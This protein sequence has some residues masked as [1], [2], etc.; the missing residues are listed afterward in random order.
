MPA[1]VGSPVLYRLHT[2]S[3][4]I[5]QIR[6]E[7]VEELEMLRDRPKRVEKPYIYHLDVGAMYPNIILTNRLQP[8]AIVDDTTCAACDY[9]QAKNDCK[10]R[11]DWVWRGDYSPASKNEYE[12]TKDQ[13]SREVIEG[14][15]FASFPEQE[16]AKHV[17]DRLKTYSRKAYKK[18][19]VTEEETRKDVVCMREN[20]FYVDTV[21]QFRDR[22]Y[23]YKKM[24]NS[25][26]KKRDSAPDAAAKKEA[27]D[28]VVVYDSL[29]VAH[30]CIL[31]SFYGYVMR[32]GAR[33]RS[34]EMAGIVTKTGSDIITEARILVEQIGRPLELDTDGIWCILP[35][36]FPDVYT[37]KTS[38]GSKLKLEYP[39]V[40]LNADVHDKFTNHQYQTL[41][42]PKRGIYETRSECSIFFEVDGPYRC[43]VIPA[44][45]EEG[46]LLKKRYAV[47][48][49]D[50]SLAELKGFELKRRGE[51]ELIK[52]FQSQVFERFLDGNSLKECY[53]SVADVANHW[54]DVI[55]TRGDSLEDDELID[56]ISE[57]RNMSR[58]LE[59]YGDQKGTSQTTARRLAEFLGADLIK[60]KGLNCKFII[61][62]QPY[63]APV[64]ERAIP[65]NIWK[66]EPGV[67]KHFLRKWMKSPGLDGDSLDIRNVLDWDYYLGRLGKTIQK[68][69]TIP[70]ALQ[71]VPNPVPRVEHPSWL[72]SK[73]N[74]LNDKFQQQSIR[75][76]FGVKGPSETTPAALVDIEDF[77]SGKQVSKRPIVHS[78]KRSSKNARE[79][80]EQKST[81]AFDNAERI[82]LS[83]E[84]FGDW[85]Q[86]KKALWQNSRRARKTLDAARDQGGVDKRQRKA[87]SMEGFVRKA[88]LSLTEREWQVIEVRGMT[89]YDALAP[90]SQSSGSGDFTVWVMTGTDSLQKISVTVPRTV[91]ISTRKEI[92]NVSDGTGMLELRKVDKHLPHSKSAAFV[93]E[94][95]MPEHIYKSK[96]WINYLKPVDSTEE[97]DDIFDG[98]Y[99]TDTPLM[100]RVLSE[101]GCLSRL[102]SAGTLA[103]ARKSYSLSELSR[104]ERPSEGEYLHSKLSYKRLFLY[105]KVHPRS[106]T[107]I[108]AL[109]VLD[110]GSGSFLKKSEDDEDNQSTHEDVTR[111][112]EATPA[113]FDI[114]ASCHVWVV[115]PGS[116]SGQRNVSK[117]HCESLFDQLI[118]TIKEAAG[119]ESEYACV[120]PKSDV[121]ISSLNFVDREDLA[122]AGANEA[123]SSYAKTNNGATFILLNSSR[124]PMQ[125]RRYMSTFASFPVVSMPFPPG[126]AHNPSLWTLPSL[127]WEQPAVQ[128]CLE[129]YLFM[130]VVAYPKRVSYSRYGQVPLGN[131]GDDE[132]VALYD[133]SLARMI[134]KN[135]A[136]SWAST[137]PGRPDLGVN[138]LPSSEGSLFPSIDSGASSYNQEEIWGDDEELVSPVIRRPGCYR[139]IC[140]DIDVQDLAIAALSEVCASL[141]S[142]AP[143]ALNQA[144]GIDPHSPNTVALFDSNF[145]MSKATGGLG[146]QMATSVSLPL[147]Q[148]LVGGWLRDAFASNSL[149]ADELLHHIFQLVSNPE[150]LLHDPALHRVTH[151][152]M[153][154]TFMRMLGELQRL[155]CS[156]VYASF[157]RVI[158]ATNKIELA[159]AE[160]YIN[161]VISTARSRAGDEDGNALARVSLRP[162]QFHSHFAF[163]DE[164]NFGT[165]HLE[166]VEQDQVEEDEFVVREEEST[167]VVVPSVVTA[168]SV[169]NYLGSEI[170]QEYFRAIIGRFSKDV[171]KKQMDLRPKDEAIH[172]SL[173]GANGNNDQL[174]NYKKKMITKH[175]ASYLTRAVGEIMKDG[176]DDEILPPLLGDR[177]R[178]MNPALE[179]IKSIIAVL[180]LDSELENEVHVLK[181]SLLAQIG[182]AEYSRA[183]QWINPCPTFI[184]PD[185]FC[186]EC[187]ESRDVNLCYVPPRD[188]EEDDSQKHWQCEDCG[189]PYDVDSIER[190]LISLLHRKMVRYQL[191]DIRCSKTNRVTTRALA[192]LSEGSNGVKLDISPK[193]GQAD[194]RLLHSLAEL[195]ELESLKEAAAGMLANFH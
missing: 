164:Y 66:A 126:P 192:P 58:Q 82:E 80:P 95:T 86:Q 3:I 85:L 125:L 12:R 25:W 9:N 155:G 63:G 81:P 160:E 88:A 71:K 150:A 110:G 183:A 62:E 48:N 147:V 74:R 76:M 175:F 1:L 79:M 154:A 115:K 17:S 84:K 176:F 118:G 98:L 170:A 36:S 168:W 189:T 64:T 136:L 18:T 184:L 101:V 103:K 90:E 133:V 104:V 19:K 92:T 112:S 142:N 41:V 28:R 14:Q 32:R 171:L 20:D 60:D 21:R 52:T 191:Q 13:L 31:N 42:D 137:V 33:W 61:A 51:L 97:T 26:K 158:V 46:K 127:N 107:G 30:K 7:I 116:R 181:R 4:Q 27:D 135:R 180:E 44:S 124:P 59:D 45:T 141:T 93:Y 8:S 83:K 166:R 35:I 15:S 151:S 67:M 111:P 121:R 38:D 37:F 2:F 172:L 182:V 123:I 99:E 188:T 130:A 173:A 22:R 39:C 117:K 94:L 102:T 10:R 149:V 6:S 162:R 40:M 152:L 144:G 16:Q 134:K 70:A 159:D 193:E 153:K 77:D 161:F 50:G 139:S 23:E 156:I 186:T 131:L 73:V 114:G 87:V 54:I 109:Y 119:L 143:G 129:A 178:P 179:F 96:K 106:K 43:M 91:Y 108:V 65:T 24:N 122:Y 148:A 145:N 105:V 146:D 55:D 72:S 49:F 69:I 195:H 163:M 167:S 53:D 47:F 78:M 140:V 174:L 11:M 100:A 190:R 68:I 169:M 187:H 56:L 75:T 157:H 177:S 113:T 165:M 185:V 5:A 89:T 34:M 128:L 29:Q 132:N 120:S 138:F 57:N 194:L